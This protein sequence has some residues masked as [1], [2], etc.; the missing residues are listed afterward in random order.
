MFQTKKGKFQHKGACSIY[1]QLQRFEIIVFHLYFSLLTTVQLLGRIRENTALDFLS[2]VN[3][4]FARK[5][6]KMQYKILPLHV[7]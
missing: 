4:Y 7:I 1:N 3:I 5:T 2:Q 6:C